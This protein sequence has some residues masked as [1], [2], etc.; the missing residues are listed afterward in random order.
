MLQRISKQTQEVSTSLDM[1][2]ASTQVVTSVSLLHYQFIESL[3]MD[4]AVHDSIYP[5]FQT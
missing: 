4:W 3:F 1:S 2:T 5:N